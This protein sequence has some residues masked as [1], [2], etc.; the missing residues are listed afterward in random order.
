LASDGSQ[1]FTEQSAGGG[2][3]RIHNTSPGHGGQPYDTCVRTSPVK[4]STVASIQPCGGT[5]EEQWLIAS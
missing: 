1:W 2:Y 5:S 4:T 3:V